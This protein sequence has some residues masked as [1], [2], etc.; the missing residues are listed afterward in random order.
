MLGRLLA[1]CAFI[2]LFP[3]TA[4]AATLQ[5]VFREDF[6]GTSI[7]SANWSLYNGPG[8]AGN[9]RRDPASCSVSNGQLV[10]TARNGLDG[11]VHSCGM[12]HRTSYTPTSGDVVVQA[13]VRVERDPSNTMSGVAILWADNDVNND[14]T[15]DPDDGEFDFWETGRGTAAVKSFIHYGNGQ[16]DSKTWPLDPAVFHTAQIR[17]SRTTEAIRMDLGEPWK[18]F[19]PFTNP[20]HVTLQLDA[21]APSLPAGAVVR[22]YVEWVRI[23]KVVPDAPPPPPPGGA[24]TIAAAGDISPP[25]ANAGNKRTSDLLVANP[26]DKV[27]TL[28]DNQYPDG[29]LSGFNSYY[30]P[31]W[32]RVKALTAP[33]PGNHDLHLACSSQGYWSY[34]GAAAGTACQ[35]YYSYDLGNWHIVALNSGCGSSSSAPNSPSCA[36]G[37]PQE[38]WLRQDLASSTKQ[39]KLVYWHHSRFSSSATSGANSTVQPFVNAAYDGGADVILNGHA[40]VYERFAPQTKTG[41]ASPTG[42]RQFTVGTGGNSLYSFLSTPAAN[43]EVRYNGGFGV[44]RMTLADGVYDWRYESEAGRTFTDTDSGTCH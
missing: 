30:N 13:K 42:F 36:T 38:Q 23:L 15:V 35:G 7:N 39:C 24:P 34:F 16:Q 17:W 26:P 1:L 12:S 37:S 11:L 22:M 18:A 40:H 4:Q 32:G 21:F 28:G 6:N 14:G 33:S 29:E 9:G 5:E 3:A 44:L 25:S 31:T 10:L 20:H 8:H 19:R 41:T 43:S 27:L 2:F